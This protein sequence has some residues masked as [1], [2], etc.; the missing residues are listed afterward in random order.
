MRKYLL[1]SAISNI[2]LQLM[3]WLC[4]I[5]VFLHIYSIYSLNLYLFLYCTALQ[6]Y[7]SFF[8][9][10]NELYIRLGRWARLSDI[11]TE[12]KIVQEEN[13]P[14]EGCMVLEFWKISFLSIPMECIIGE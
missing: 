6:I 3:M 10:R 11:F 7:T 2:V 4:P 1:R 8:A 9:K 14:K 12:A 13:P 5:H